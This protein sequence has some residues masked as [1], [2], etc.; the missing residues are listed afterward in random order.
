MNHNI[1]LCHLYPEL[2]DT[3]GDRGNIIALTQRA[4]WRGIEVSLQEVSLYEPLPDEPVDIYFLGGGQDQAQGVIANDI[5]TKADRLK[6]DIEAGVVAL[7]ICG[8]YQL[9]GRNYVDPT[10]RDIPGIGIF[11]IQTK[12]GPTRRV[13]DLLI[14]TN[15]IIPGVQLVGFEN[16]SGLTFLDNPDQALGSVIKGTGNNGQDNTEGIVYKNAIGTYLHGSLL[17]KNPRL[18]DYLLETALKRKYPDFVLEKLD[19]ALEEQAF[20]EAVR[21]I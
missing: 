3:Y 6:N 7:T 20:R 4:K 18:T 17:P 5:K 8:G 21:Q 10:G 15:S 19:N 13:N 11:D 1:T 16:H 2:M 14:E 12:G 9:F